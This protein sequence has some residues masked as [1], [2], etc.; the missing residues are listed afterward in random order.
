MT[1]LILKWHADMFDMYA[2]VTSGKKGKIINHFE[3]RTKNG[4][5]VTHIIRDGFVVDDN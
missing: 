5:K 3:I 2:T 4:I 1:S